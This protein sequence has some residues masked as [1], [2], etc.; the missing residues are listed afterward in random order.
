MVTRAEAIENI[1]GEYANRASA[2][3]FAASTIELAESLRALGVTDE[4]LEAA[5]VSPTRR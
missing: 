1:V 4:E 2:A 5:G 3:E